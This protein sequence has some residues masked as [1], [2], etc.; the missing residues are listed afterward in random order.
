MIVVSDRAGAEPSTCGLEDPRIAAAAPA[1]PRKSSQR[2]TTPFLRRTRARAS[3][4]SGVV[5]RGA[6]GGALAGKTVYVSAG[7]GLTWRDADAVWR[8]Q[9]GNTHDLVEDF[10][11]IETIAQ[12]LIPYLR[13]MGAYVVPVRE[14]DLNANL[15]IV[16]DAG[17]DFS[18]EG[19]LTMTDEPDG[20]APVMLPIV[21]N[22]NPF[23]GGTSRVITTAATETGRAVWTFDVPEAGAYNVY[24]GYRQDPSRASDAH[25]IVR[26]AGGEAHYRIDQRRHGSTW[27][28]LGRFYFQAGRS[29]DRGAIVLANDSAEAGATL[30]ADVAR[31]GGGM[32]VIDRG[33]G[34]S[35][36][37]MFE[38]CARY[39]AQLA[40]APPS[41]YDYAG[42]DG[43]DDV[44]T[45][46]RFSAWDH[47][48]G[49]DAVY[50]AWHTNAP[51]PA[52][53]T[54]SFA[55]GPSSYGPL[56]EFSGVPGSLELMDAV[57]SELI[58]DIRALWQADWQDRGQHT[59]YFGE[60]NPNHNPEMPAALFEIAFH[61]TELDAAALRDPRF[62][63]LAARAMAQGVAKYFAAR[64]GAAL[65]LPPE[66][67][68]RVRAQQLEP[69]VMRVSWR[70]PAAD[71]A[72]G[73]AAT[74]YRVYLSRDGLAF[75]DGTEIS[76]DQLDLTVDGD[77]PVYVRV[78]AT[79]PG[80]ESFPSRVV[81]ARP[82][83][84][85]TA[86]VL[87][88]AGFD[89]IDA[90]MLIPEDLSA[91]ALATIERGFVAHINDTSHVARW[92]DAVA[93]AGVSF[94]SA[95]ATAV[96]AGDARLDDY[97]VVLWFTGEESAC[98][99][100]LNVDERAAMASYVA[101]DGKLLVSGSELLWT[102][103]ERG[104][105]DTQAFATSVLH[106]SYAGDDAGTYAVTGEADLNG[107]AFSFD[108]TGPGS[109]DAEFPDIV[110][111]ADA[112]TQLVLAYAGGTGGGAATLWR[113][114]GGEAAVMVLGFP[115]ETIDG[116]DNRAEVMARILASFA[117]E[118]DGPGTEEPTDP[119]IEGGCGCRSGEDHAPGWLLLVT[120][121]ALGLCRRR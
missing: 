99:E 27:V 7:H 85:G 18:V 8:T 31:I 112:D 73:D 98:C 70:A 80:G 51:D 79:N 110:A 115:F 87:I 109:Y 111:P 55:Y 46:S 95:S 75:D 20:Y 66:P 59:A 76:G 14:T 92:G 58:D 116:A 121:L 60:V 40:G 63:Q 113:D 23:S 69:G 29:S 17:A 39:H 41:V 52:R 4:R 44:G 93:A 101:N 78:T 61:S 94:D 54:S 119:R 34:T 106:A 19:E 104:D 38:N 100:P 84:S 1:V 32:G 6:A 33:G 118:P 64:D 12:Y 21:D 47:E 114:P 42:A 65:T 117:I 107:L 82:S 11:S 83:P 57:H 105:A 86:Q 36:R 26:H 89:R 37:P 90:A 96:A 25:Y 81:G 102:L 67:P 120:L 28:L 108:D 24:I 77:E 91:Y 9:R 15:V 48:D 56:S 16:D 68:T 50:L 49:E 97:R 30:S 22:T 74:G 35:G 103:V 10:I 72:G 13:N 3:L 88:V 2:F 43:S 62:R 45:R 53:G 5:G 71:P